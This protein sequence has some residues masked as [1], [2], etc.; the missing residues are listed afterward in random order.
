V[1]G[2]PLVEADQ[3][4]DDLRGALHSGESGLTYV[5]R[6]LCKV[7]ETGAWRERYDARTRQ[8]VRFGTFAEFTITPATEGLGATD[9][10]IDRI[11]GTDDPDLLRN[12]RKARRPGRGS[13]TDK[14]PRVESTPSRAMEDSANTAERLARDAPDEYAAVLRGERT[15]H[16]AA[17]RAGIRRR[18]VT[19]RMDSAE[20]AAETLR[21]N[22]APEQIAALVKLL[23]EPPAD[24]P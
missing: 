3:L 9:E 11:V 1:A 13:R 24:R 14:V 8:T 6:L 15:L 5:P 4:V 22:M 20:S 10:L 18:R 19:V 2:D 17:V 12:L 21:R 16:A 23:L 7:L